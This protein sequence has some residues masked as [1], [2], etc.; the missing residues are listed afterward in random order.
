MAGGSPARRGF[1]HAFGRCHNCSISS[2]STPA[3]L[4]PSIA[5]NRTISTRADSLK[6]HDPRR[7]ASVAAS[8]YLTENNVDGH[9]HS[10]RGLPL[11]V[12][13]LI[14]SSPRRLKPSSWANAID[15]YLPLDLRSGGDTDTEESIQYEAWRPIHTLPEVLATARAYCK[16]DLLSYI[17]VYQ[18][19]WTAVIWLVKAVMDKYPGYRE[20]GRRSCQLPP[21]LWDTTDQNLN[22]VTGHA[23][24]IDVSQASKVS[25]KHNRP[26]GFFSLDQYPWSRTSD[27]WDKTYNSGLRGLGQ[28]WQSL[29][30]MILQAAD[31]PAEGSSYSIIMSYVFQILG[32]LHRINAFPDSIYNYTPPKDPNVLQRPPTLHLLSKRIMGTLS[33][34]EWGLQWEVMITEA[35]SQGYDLP[36][37]NVQPRL[38]EFGPELWLDLILWACVEGGWISEG[39]WIIIEMQRRRVSKDTRWSTISWSKICEVKAPKLDWTSI[40]KLEIDKTRLNQVGGIGIAT[41][42]NSHIEMGTRTISREVV[43][44]LFDGLLNDPQ[45]TPASLG[46]TVVE[47]QRSIAACKGLLDCNDSELDHQFMNAAILRIYESFEN[48]KERPRSLNRILD[49]RSTDLKQATRSSSMKASAQDQE[50]DDCA[51]ILGL[52][53]RNL[54]YLSVDGD[55]E[56]S[57]RTLG[58]I[59]STID[60]QREGKILSFADELKGRLGRG[61]DVSDLIADGEDRAALIQPP[62]IPTS[63]LVS[64]VDLITNSRLFD[65]GNWLLLNKDIDGGLMDFASYSHQNLQPALLRFGTATS[66]SRL[67]TKVLSGMETPLSEPV[68]H[69]LLRFQVALGKWTAVEELLEYLKG[70]SDMAWKPSDATSIARA[71]LQM[72]H[73]ASNHADVDSIPRALSLVQNLVNG[74]YNSKAD[75]SQLIPDFTQTRMANQLGRILRTLPGSLSKITTRPPGADLRTHAS[76]DITPNAFNIL[77]ETMVDHYGSFA[78]QKLWDQWCREPKTPKREQK[79]Y[80]LLEDRERVVTPTLYMLRNALRPVLETRRALHVAMN[81]ELKISRDTKSATKFRLVDGDQ[82]ILDWGIRLY[83]KFGLSNNEINGE[84]PGLFPQ[85]MRAKP[86]NNEHQRSM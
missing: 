39:A 67:L 70:A 6:Y 61:D 76:V 59:Q 60:Q 69:A 40:L 85:N 46:M 13:N 68:V 27:R 24:Q 34:V 73:Q 41:G 64:F 71:I 15:S 62:Q 57:L 4:A 23:I 37:A 81:E 28:I 83:K 80:A 79:S 9:I 14:M 56:G 50:I 66:N 65:L 51:A 22:E 52:Y 72:E 55:L 10:K 31:R 44:A 21:P 54:T 7:R 84:I 36:K 48:V 26:D 77:L 86:V 25:R 45:S 29:G 5:Q 74:K 49:L 19:R 63:A 38:R 11:D 3:F 16:T 8:H 75:P 12:E 33:D 43:L 32:H 58:K 35:R 20:I 30:T 1:V 78:G 2:T 42:S 18:E 17:G 47:L 53:H 82:K